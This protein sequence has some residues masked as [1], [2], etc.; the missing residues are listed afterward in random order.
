MGGCSNDSCGDLT[1]TRYRRILWI[2]LVLNAGMFF[3]EVFVMSVQL[4]YLLI[5]IGYN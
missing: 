1:D 4:Q 5:C 2:I 3:V